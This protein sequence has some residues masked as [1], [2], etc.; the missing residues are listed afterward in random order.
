MKHGLG[1]PQEA[2]DEE[3]E[4]NKPTLKD[5]IG[6]FICT[7]IYLIILIITAINIF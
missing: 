5:D 6:S 1:T 7:I 3:R 2:Y 4:W